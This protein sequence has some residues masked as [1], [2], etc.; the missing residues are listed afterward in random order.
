[1]GKKFSIFSVIKKFRK[2][3]NLGYENVWNHET[4]SPNMVPFQWA[5]KYKILP[6]FRTLTPHVTSQSGPNMINHIARYFRHHSI[7][8]HEKDFLKLDYSFRA[9]DCPLAEPCVNVLSF[10]WP[11]LSW[12]FHIFSVTYVTYE[13]ESFSSMDC[14]LLL[15][16]LFKLRGYFVIPKKVCFLY[17]P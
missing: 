6:F 12:W 17:C 1:M 4:F 13:H 15:D 16:G 11:P 10:N 2:N 7:E 9:N 5:R 8:I 3:L 14:N